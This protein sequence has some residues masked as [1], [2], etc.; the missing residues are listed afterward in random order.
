MTTEQGDGTI[1]KRMAL[2]LCPKCETALPK[3][4]RSKCR[5]CGLVVQ[6][7]KAQDNGVLP[8]GSSTPFIDLESVS[9]MAGALK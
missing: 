1:A 9:D 8:Q 3:G 6:S 4:P 2:G 7:G 5:A